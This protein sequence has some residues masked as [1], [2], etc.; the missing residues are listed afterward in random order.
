MPVSLAALTAQL[1]ATLHTGD[2]GL[3]PADLVTDVAALEHA[4]PSDLTYVERERHLPRLS[5][6]KAGALLIPEVLLTRVREYYAGPLLTVAEPKEAFIAAMVALRPP[7]PRTSIGVSARAI[8]ADSVQVG[9]DTNVHPLACIGERVVIG[10]G[11]D[12]HPGVVIGDDCR[13]G[14]GVTI[15]P[16][17]VLYAGVQVGQRVIIHAAAVIGADGFGYSF[18]EG[19]YVKIPHTGTVRIEDDVEIGAGTTI[20]RG[21]VGATVI[22]AGTKIDNQVM[23]AHNCEIGRHNAFA[24]QVGFAGSTVTE[25][26]VRCGGQAGIADHLRLGKGSTLGPKAGVH[27]DVPPGAKYHGMPAGP[28]K[29]QIR[30]H[31]HVQKLPEMR[32]ELQALIRRVAELEQQ[33]DDVAATKAA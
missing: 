5:G 32:Q 14:D 23:V 6:S 17:A 3:G 22:G 4:G 2:A 18:K 12:I 8:V 16:N 11:C 15:Y 27:V 13:I 24:S 31:L 33:C 28:D 20:D 7:A 30:V 25:D 1:G 29:E 26:Y 19:E 10:A 9:A 21:M